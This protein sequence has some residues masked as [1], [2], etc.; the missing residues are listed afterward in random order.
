MNVNLELP[1]YL[2]EKGVVIRKQIK[3]RQLW[4]SGF[5]TGRASVKIDVLGNAGSL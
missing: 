1:S 4:K 5:L 2:A 3:K